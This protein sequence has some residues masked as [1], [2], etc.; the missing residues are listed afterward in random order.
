MT[1]SQK[2]PRVADAALEVMKAWDAD[3]NIGVI[4]LVYGP[5]DDVDFAQVSFA[6]SSQIA[7]QFAGNP[8]G[9][10]IAVGW[11][12]DNTL[13]DRWSVTDRDRFGPDPD[14]LLRVLKVFDRQYI[15]RLDEF[16]GSTDADI[17]L[18]ITTA[19]GT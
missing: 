7:N 6:L 3:D 13:A 14:I 15:D 5:E 18:A 1:Q 4:V 10:Q 19:L 12:L 17:R 8:P 11:L 16:A 9:R 2:L